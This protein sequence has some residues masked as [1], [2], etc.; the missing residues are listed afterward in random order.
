[1]KSSH[2]IGMMFIGTQVNFKFV[3]SRIRNITN[4]AVLVKEI[5]M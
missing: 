3:I 4:G 1:M 5:N 2:K